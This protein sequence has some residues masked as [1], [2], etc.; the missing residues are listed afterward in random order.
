MT[1]GAGGGG[2]GGHGSGPGWPDSMTIPKNVFVEGLANYRDF[3]HVHTRLTTR[4]AL[5]IFLFA[6]VIPGGI[7]AISAFQ[8]QRMEENRKALFPE[9][10]NALRAVE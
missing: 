8:T 9:R 6:V 4:R 10:K 1:V 2:H 5:A 3:L 7:G